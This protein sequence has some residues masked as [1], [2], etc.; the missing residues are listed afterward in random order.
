MVYT[1]VPERWGTPSTPK[2]VVSTHFAWNS[3]FGIFV[4]KVWYLKTLFDH[5]SNRSSF[6]KLNLITKLRK[7]KVGRA[8]W[9]THLTLHSRAFIT[10][11]L[12]CLRK[13]YLLK[14]KNFNVKQLKLRIFFKPCLAINCYY[15]KH[16]TSGIL[17]TPL[18][19]YILFQ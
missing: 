10:A 7:H 3:N 6:S 8:Q 5:V 19:L 16:Y 11:V 12:F 9:L 17:I 1:G 18:N 13:I 14:N 2:L 15:L 4:Q